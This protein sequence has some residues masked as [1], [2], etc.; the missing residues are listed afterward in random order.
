M[1]LLTQAVSRSAEQGDTVFFRIVSVL[2]QHLG[3]SQRYAVVVLS[4][5]G[6]EVRAAS[7]HLIRPDG[8]IVAAGDYSLVVIPPVEGV[9]LSAGFTPDASLLAWL[10]TLRQKGTSVLAMTTGVCFVAAAGLAEQRLLATQWA[11]MRRLKKCYPDCQLVSQQSFLQADGI[12][13]TGSLSGGFDALL[14]LLAQD[15]GDQFSQLCATH[16]LVSAPE[17][18]SPILPGHRNHCDEAIL[19]SQ[20]WIEAHHAESLTIERMGR[21]VVLAERTLKRRFQ[22]ATRLSPILYLQMVWIDKAKKLLLA[23]SSSVKAIAYEVGYENVS[24]FVRLFRT[25]TGQTLAQWRECK[26]IVAS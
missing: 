14:E 10:T 3:I 13:S 19:R 23:T 22:Q 26:S 5:D 18:L 7:G 16:L 15:C 11:Y 4:T 2:E 12:W 6:A 20:D 21:E 8:A 17:R 1:G 9:L 25:L 24:F